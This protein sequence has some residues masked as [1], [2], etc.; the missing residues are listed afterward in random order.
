MRSPDLLKR[1]LRIYG[2]TRSVE[3]YMR[4]TGYAHSTVVRMASTVRVSLKPGNKPGN[5]PRR[6]TDPID[7]FLRLA[8]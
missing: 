8:A 5:R 4:Q 7:R 1:L 3:W 2:S 6:S